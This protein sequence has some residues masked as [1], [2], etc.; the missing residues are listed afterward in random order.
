MDPR[1][2]IILWLCVACMISLSPVIGTEQNF[3]QDEGL[4]PESIKYNETSIPVGILV[5]K[6]GFVSDIGTEYSRSFTMAEQDATVAA[7]Q[8]RCPL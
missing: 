4:Q 2:Q 5:M 6:T 3:P 8:L 7:P 1:F